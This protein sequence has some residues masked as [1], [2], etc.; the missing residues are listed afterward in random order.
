PAMEVAAQLIATERRA[1]KPDQFIGA[2]Q[3]IT[4]LGAGG[5][6]EVFLAQDTR[7]GRKVALK[8]FDSMGDSQSRA[9]FLREA[10]LASAL[11]HPNICAIYEIGEAA[12][13]H[14]IAMQYVEGKTLDQLIA[15]QPL[16]LD[17]LLSISLQVAAAL[18]TA[19]S[20]GIIHRDIKPSN[21]I[22]T[23]RGQAKVLDFGLARL[24]GEEPGQQNELTS[25]AVV[26][27]TPAYM[28][29]DQACGG[30]LD[31]RSDIFSF[32]VALYQMATGRAPFKGKTPSETIKAVISQ[33]HT[34]V[35]EL[36]Q[37][38]PPELA[39]MIDRALA[40]DAAGRY[41]SMQELID[42]LRQVAAQSGSLRRFLKS[43]E[44]LDG[45]LTP[46]LPARRRELFGVPKKI[47]AFSALT[48]VA[49][50]TILA[51]WQNKLGSQ[52][53]RT[54]PF[55]SMKIS[56]VTTVGNVSDAAI[57]PDGKILVY[58][59]SDKG[60]RS[61]WVKQVAADADSSIQIMPPSESDYRGITFSRDSNYVYYLARGENDPSGALYQAPVLGGAPKRLLVNIASPITFSPD[62]KRFA[63]VR[64]DD[65]R[66][67]DALMIA[68]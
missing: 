41:P 13:R 11:D 22:V 43:G 67:K 55:H 53:I 45:M 32:G 25:G 65:A 6:G 8:L 68:N 5:M 17:S 19:H 59:V 56:R 1:I 51:L 36:N 48:L 38:A 63:F 24:L 30:P 15:G 21:I 60:R 58:A 3:I 49:A 14:F 47:A 27:G 18:A 54:A 52:V 16:E 61:L 37:E 46:Y 20:Q 42:D 31:Q 44:S 4:Q 7:L 62:S 57:S 26:M 28:S 2:Y 10:Q 34:P 40:K 35:A 66:G 50:L 23:P 33:P 64:H 29:P 39:A 9:R 12:G